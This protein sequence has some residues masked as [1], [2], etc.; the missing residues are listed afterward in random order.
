MCSAIVALALTVG[1]L[2]TVPGESA[3]GQLGTG[4]V[5]GTVED[6]S[7]AVLPGATVTVTNGAGTADD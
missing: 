6:A 2:V 4:S 7:G 5:G 1:F 3:Q